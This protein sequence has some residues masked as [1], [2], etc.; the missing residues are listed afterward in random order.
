MACPDIDVDQIVMPPTGPSRPSR[1]DRRGVAPQEL[2]PVP[3]RTGVLSRCSLSGSYP[4]R[5]AKKLKRG[6]KMSAMNQ[7]QMKLS[8]RPR[9]NVDQLKS[10]KPGRKMPS[11]SCFIGRPANTRLPITQIT[12]KNTKKRPRLKPS[13]DPEQ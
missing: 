8:T 13:E 7:P 9:K 12:Q 5:R 2:S 4:K 10:S 1:P 11:A 6:V 3:G